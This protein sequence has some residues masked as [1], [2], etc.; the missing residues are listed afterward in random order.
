MLKRYITLLVCLALFVSILTGCG[1]TESASKKETE[2]LMDVSQ[3]SRITSEELIAK[4]GDSEGK[5][6]ENWTNPGTGTEYKMTSYD[7]TLEGYYTEFL[8]IENEVVRMNIYS[9]DNPENKFILSEPKD[10]LSLVGI[11]LRDSLNVVEENEGTA[12]YSSVSDQ[13]GE[14]WATLDN[15]TVDILKVTFNLNYFN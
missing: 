10:I 13:V 11:T 14:V 15:K 12:R 9:S 7:Y 4:L 6:E 2:Q 8:V 1:K 3:Y 5:F